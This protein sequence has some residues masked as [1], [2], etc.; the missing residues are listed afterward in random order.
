MRQRPLT[1]TDWLLP[2]AEAPQHEID[3]RFHAIVINIVGAPTELVDEH[4]AVAWQQR[5][6]LCGHPLPDAVES[7]DCPLCLPGQFHDAETGPHCN[8]FR[9]YDPATAHSLSPDPLGL[10]PDLIDLYHAM[11]AAS[12]RDRPTT[13]P[14]RRSRLAS[15]PL[16]NPI[17]LKPLVTAF[18]TIEH[19]VFTPYGRARPPARARPAHSS[20]WTGT[21]MCHDRH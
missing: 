13:G 5:T 19:P 11:P 17:Q 7:I 9:Y 18:S 20:T 12:S 21:D 3:R 8:V 10:D 4:G 16:Q 1:Q 2:I 15:R 14:T 6:A